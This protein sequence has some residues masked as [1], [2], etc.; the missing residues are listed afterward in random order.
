[1]TKLSKLQKSAVDQLSDSASVL[2][3]IFVGEKLIIV[4][5]I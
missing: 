4:S 2:V 1:M 5:S 3:E